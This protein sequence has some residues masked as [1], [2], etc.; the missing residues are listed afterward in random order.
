MFQ[1]ILLFV[2]FYHEII[3]HQIAQKMPILSK[4]LLWLSIF[5]FKN[6]P[7]IVYLMLHNNSFCPFFKN[8][9]INSSIECKY[10]NKIQIIFTLQ[11]FGMYRLQEQ[12]HICKYTT[13]WC[14]LL[15]HRWLLFCTEFFKVFENSYR[16][17]L[18]MWNSFGPKLIMFFV[19]IF[20]TFFYAYN[21]F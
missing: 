1:I 18:Q 16:K 15:V 6:C 5:K 20:V 2:N 11:S 14:I 12:W 4:S 13:Y 21:S 10:P 7:F 9:E 8:V 17:V 3:R 19:L